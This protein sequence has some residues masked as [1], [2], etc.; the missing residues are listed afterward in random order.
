MY[1][2]NITKRNR[3][4]FQAGYPR[5]L[6]Y[7]FPHLY[8]ILFSSINFAIL[9]FI[10]LIVGSS[11]YVL[12]RVVFEVFDTLYYRRDYK[13]LAEIFIHNEKHKDNYILFKWASIHLPLIIGELFIFF[14]IFNE[15]D[16]LFEKYRWKILIIFCFFWLVSFIAYYFMH[17]I[18]KEIYIKEK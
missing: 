11:V 10:A 4:S 12:H 6:Q 18:Q 15:P 5:L 9:S 7:A 13:K 2:G 8:G 14:C 16:S 1:F 3:K 17:R